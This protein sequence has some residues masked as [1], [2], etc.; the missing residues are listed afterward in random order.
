MDYKFNKTDFY[1]IALYYAFAIPINLMDYNAYPEKWKLFA[2]LFAYSITMGVSL[3][4]LVYVIFVRFFPKR[5]YVQIFIWSIL[6]FIVMGLVDINIHCYLFGCRRSPFT[7][8]YI[9]Y[10]ISSI[11]ESVGLISA[12]LLGKK[13]YDAQLYQN[14]LEKEQRENELRILKAQINPH[15]LFNN[16][17]TVDVLID[18][19]PQKAKLYLKKLSALYRYLIANKDNEVV[20]LEEE[21]EFVHNYLYLIQARYGNAYEFDI[22]MRTEL[23]DALIPPGA[24]Q[25]LLENIVKHNQGNETNPLKSQITINQQYIK[26]A[27]DL[28]PKNKQIDSTGIG[29]SNLKARYKLLSDADIQIYKNKQFIVE[30][31]TIKQ[32][33]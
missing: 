24:L 20:P 16:L 27:N 14:K 7:L 13:L 25:T 2:E 1:L 18:Q 28:A 5:Q 9:F 12:V 31:P 11:T 33:D 19:N 4:F 3:Y 23:N 6:L 26:V 15:F 29:L 32:V 22:E 17:N 8:E 10:G 30:L 21:L